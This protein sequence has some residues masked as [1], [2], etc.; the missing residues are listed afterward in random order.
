MLLPSRNDDNL[1]GGSDKQGSAPSVASLQ[2]TAGPSLLQPDLTCLHKEHEIWDSSL[3]RQVGTPPVRLPPRNGERLSPSPP[4]ESEQLHV[5]KLRLRRRVGIVLPGT[6]HMRTCDDHD[7]I[8][9]IICHTLNDHIQDA[10]QGEYA[11]CPYFQQI[12]GLAGFP[13]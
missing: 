3:G 4:R 9:G 6:V 8:Q 13:R 1:G 2:G 5:F 7:E 12:H 10:F 11:E